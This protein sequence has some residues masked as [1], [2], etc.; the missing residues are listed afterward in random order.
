MRLKLGPL[1]LIEVAAFLLII[2][3]SYAFFSFVIIFGS[4]PHN[5]E[6]LTL[7]AAVRIVLTAA[8][9]VVWFLV[10]LGLTRL[11]VRSKTRNAPTPSS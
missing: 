4:F 1:I 11:Y 10:V 8:L 9:G 6:D 7:A 5:L 2:G 3:E